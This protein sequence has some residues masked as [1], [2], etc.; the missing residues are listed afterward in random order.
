MGEFV[1]AA[2]CMG[3][4]WWGAR[5]RPLAEPRR[6]AEGGMG[7][8]VRAAHCMGQGHDIILTFAGA[9]S[10]LQPRLPTSQIGIGH[11]IWIP[12]DVSLVGGLLQS[13]T[14]PS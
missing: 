12:A 1:R 9:C 11:T 5:L 4:A 2:H 10:Y 3:L 6:V 8:F 13:S 7:E 14:T